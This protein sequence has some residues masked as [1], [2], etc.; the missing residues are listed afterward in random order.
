MVDSEKLKVILFKLSAAFAADPAVKL[1]GLL[2]VV[3][4]TGPLPSHF[5]YECISFLLRDWFY[6]TRPS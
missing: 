1:E 6:L 5:Q 3:F 2:P 4:K